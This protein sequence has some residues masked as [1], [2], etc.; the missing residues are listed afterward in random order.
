MESQWVTGN[1]TFTSKQKVTINNIYLPLF[2]MKWHFLASFNFLPER[3]GTEQHSYQIILGMT[4]L[5]CL[6]MY[7]DLKKDL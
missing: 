6:G 5:W 7:F 4:N 1:G 2:T 3:E